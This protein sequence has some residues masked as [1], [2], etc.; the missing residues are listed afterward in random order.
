[1]KKLIIAGIILIS[2][3]SFA[4]VKK[5]NITPP[6]S[7]KLSFEFFT[8]GSDGFY[9]REY[10]GNAVVDNREEVVFSYNNRIEKIK[11]KGIKISIKPFITG[12]GTHFL[13]KYYKQNKRKFF[14]IS[15]SLVNHRT[16]KDSKIQIVD[17]EK[18]YKLLIKTENLF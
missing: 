9:N 8:R 10:S 11:G 16:G 5:H 15:K 1:M 3:R 6:K 18:V 2:A 4:L 17:G 14:L 12:K 13:V 7:L